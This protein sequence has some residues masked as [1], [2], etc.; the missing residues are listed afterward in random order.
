MSI[1]DQS[2]WPNPEAN[3]LVIMLERGDQWFSNTEINTALDPERRN[4]NRSVIANWPTLAEQLRDGDTMI[5]GRTFREP[6]NDRQG[7][8]GGVSRYFSQRALILII[9]RA[10][11]IN[12]AACRDWIATAMADTLS[13]HE[14]AAQ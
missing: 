10:Q 6:T 1:Y 9:M 4:K 11:T 7:R 12:A 5:E 14:F 2:K 3:P 8:T 13:A